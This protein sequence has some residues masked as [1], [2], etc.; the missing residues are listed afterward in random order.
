MRIAVYTETLPADQDT[1]REK[2]WFAY[3]TLNHL[4]ADHPDQ[5]FIIITDG[6]QHPPFREAGHV[7]QI[8]LNSTAKHSLALHRRLQSKLPGLLKSEHADKLL[9]LNGLLPAR[10]V[11]PSCLVVANPHF[12]TK[13]DATAH[14]ATRYR[15]RHFRGN[16]EKAAAIA[17]VS[18][19]LKKDLMGRYGVPEEKITVI[20]TGVHQA[21]HPLG[22]EA[23][24][25]VKN[26]YTN[27]QEYFIHTGVITPNVIGVMK[28]FSIFK[29]RLRSNMMLVLAGARAPGYKTFP[30]LLDTY[31]FREDVKVTGE[32]GYEALARLTG[33]A[34]ALICPSP[35][36]G[37]DTPVLEAMKCQ[38]PVV[39]T[40]AVEE[41][42][43]EAALY[44][45]PS[46]VEEMGDKCCEI[47]KDES[48]RARMI[49]FTDV[50]A[51]KFSWDHTA[52]L[53]WS[54]LRQAGK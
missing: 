20:N 23:R 5:E 27:G 17:T 36:E 19:A 40:A 54:S 48:L 26:D 2:E 6:P 7:R 29:K 53:L 16:L 42:G 14:A 11:V 46:S 32:L 43:G 34:Y 31:H 8:P 22:W 1:W 33:A 4:I 47:Y 39:A 30:E 28:A 15:K 38:V 52:E 41:T 45:N 18:P 51:Q 21:F 37:F 49:A 44:F 13:P 12:A 25:Q 24:E 3:E 9:C 10:G 50:Q 35:S